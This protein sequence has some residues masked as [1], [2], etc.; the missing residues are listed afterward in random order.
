MVSL[1]GKRAK[2]DLKLPISVCFALYLRNCR[3]YHQDF[4]KDI[5]RCFS[6][7]FLK[8]SNI[9]N[10]RIILFLLAHLTVFLIIICFSSSSINSWKRFWGVPHLL[11][12]FLIFHL[13]WGLMHI[14]PQIVNVWGRK[15]LSLNGKICFYFCFLLRILN[16]TN[17][18]FN[19]G[20][21]LLL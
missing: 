15:H 11:H 21:I 16:K 5:Y 12:M 4:D 18:K 17:G 13:D 9:L 7:S 19:D 3:S 10:I 6:F 1:E 14:H 8:K 20:K 2:N